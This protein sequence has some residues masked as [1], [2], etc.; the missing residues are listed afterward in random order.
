LLCF[1]GWL[2]AL[3]TQRA[4]AA[5]STEQMRERQLEAYTEI[6]DKSFVSDQLFAQTIFKSLPTSNHTFTFRKQFCA[7]LALT[8]LFSYLFNCAAA[9]PNKLLFAKGSGRVWLQDIAARY[10]AD[11]DRNRATE[12]PYRRAPAAAPC[13]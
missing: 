9:P 3:V 12:L 13:S 1:F 6:I 10:T 7:Q 11:R 5:V 2:G 4:C 8:A